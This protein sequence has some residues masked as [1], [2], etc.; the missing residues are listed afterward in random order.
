MNI[1]IIILIIATV[2]WIVAEVYLVIRDNVKGKGK[3]AIDRRTRNQLSLRR[4]S[5][6]IKKLTIL[7][8]TWTL[9]S[10]GEQILVLTAK[11]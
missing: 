1:E 2:V 11:S 9:P 7:P 10:R 3:T 6:F 4:L 8:F 5:S